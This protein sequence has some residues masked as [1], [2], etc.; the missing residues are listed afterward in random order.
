MLIAHA[1]LAWHTGAH[2]P[3]GSASPHSRTRT[4]HREVQRL[5]GQQ[6]KV[7]D[8]QDRYSMPLVT[9]KHGMG[10]NEEE[11]SQMQQPAQS[12]G[13]LSYG[14][15]CWGASENMSQ[16]AHIGQASQ[17]DHISQ[18]RQQSDLH[19][20]SSMLN[21]AHLDQQGHD[22]SDEPQKASFSGLAEGSGR[23]DQVQLSYSLAEGQSAELDLQ[24]SATSQF[25]GTT[26]GEEPS[27]HAAALLH[28]TSG[29]PRVLQAP[30]KVTDDE[31]QIPAAV[32]TEK[33]LLIHVR[34]HCTTVQEHM[35]VSPSAVHGR[36]KQARTD[37]VRC[38]KF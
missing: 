25:W 7:M 33:A 38:L 17:H 2:S 18:L 28:Q 21:H 20:M 1:L 19:Q 4:G 30:P 5:A 14:Q 22:G 36:R 13:Q 8:H 32:R 6:P 3:T 26:A 31:S 37:S 9:D 15:Q 27:L 16:Q 35:A 29:L 11:S 23:D 24:S 10:S 12:S 34:T